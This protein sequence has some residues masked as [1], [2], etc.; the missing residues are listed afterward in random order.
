MGNYW[1]T[2]KKRGENFY[3]FDTRIYFDAVSSIEEKDICI[4]AVVGKNPGS[5]LPKDVILNTP[6]E[7]NLAGDKLLPTLRNILKIANPSLG[8]RK[9]V[10]VLNVFYLC[11]PNLSE[12]IADYKKEDR[13]SIEIICD[14]ERCD[15]N[16]LWFLWGGNDNQLNNMK[17]RFKHVKANKYFFLNNRDKKMHLDFP[18]NNV[19]AKHTQGMSHDLVIP[20]LTEE[21]K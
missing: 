20:F 18:Q 21:L 6:C 9:Y 11:N 3:R 4:G 2:F 5:A 12:A 17:S 16:W 7:I 19:C 8:G 15:F 13:S 14:K 1:A 10:Q